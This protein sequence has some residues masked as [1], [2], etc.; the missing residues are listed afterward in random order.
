MGEK[1]QDA[2]VDAFFVINILISLAGIVLAAMVL[3]MK[4]S[5]LIETEEKGGTTSAATRSETSSVENS[6]ANND[7][8][9]GTDSIKYAD[10]PMHTTTRS[11]IEARPLREWL[12]NHL[13]SLDAPSIFAVHQAFENDGIKTF[14]DLVE[15]IKGKVIDVSEVKNYTRAG[16]LSKMD[17]LA[18]IKAIEEATSISAMGY[19]ASQSVPSATRR[20]SIQAVTSTASPAI[21]NPVNI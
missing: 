15:C 2:A 9:V 5:I 14:N 4:S 17:T 10:N 3:V 6:S 19:W 21:I 11:G 8:E 13:P 18:I 1:N 16:K 7:E 20:A 12:A